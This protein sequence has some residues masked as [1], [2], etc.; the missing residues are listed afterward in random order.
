MT[1][2]EFKNSHKEINNKVDQL[3]NEL[4][5]A[6]WDKEEVR[7]SEDFQTLKRKYEKAFKELQNFN[8][9]A[10]KKHQ[11]QLRKETRGY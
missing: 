8:K 6:D 5:A 10:N 3:S 2:L 1:Y 4:N 7:M 11:V 9:S